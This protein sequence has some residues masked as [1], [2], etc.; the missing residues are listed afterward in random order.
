MTAES[1]L[2]TRR[3]LDDDLSSPWACLPILSRLCGESDLRLCLSRGRNADGFNRRPSHPT[4]PPFTRPCRSFWSAFAEHIR[5][6]TSPTDFCNCY[7]VRATK[8][9]LL[10]LAGTEASTSFLFSTRHAAFL[11]EALARGEPRDAQ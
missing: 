10:I 9:R 4:R 3:P 7:D 2:A 1:L 11:A 5:G 8:P 6:Q